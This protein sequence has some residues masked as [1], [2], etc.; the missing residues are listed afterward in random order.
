MPNRYPTLL[1]P[2]RLNDKVIL[3]NHITFP[4]ALQG[5]N[6]GPETFPSDAQFA[7]AN[8][9]A[10]SGASLFSYSH[11]GKFGGG[12]V[13]NR[14]AGGDKARIP[15]FDYDDPSMWNYMCQ[16]TTQAHMY[17]SRILI[18]FAAA[19][20]AG[21][22]YYGGNAR[23]LFPVPGSG[24][25]PGGPSGPGGGPGGPGG[26]PGG[27]KPCPKE[28]FPQVMDEMIDM[29][30]KYR[31]NGFDGM[32]FRLDRYID[33]ATNIR[34]DEYGGPIENRGRFLVELFTRVKDEVGRDFIIEGAL[35]YT[36]DHG[37]DGELPFGYSF[38]EVC[39]LARMLE[40]NMDIIQLREHTATGYHPTGYNVTR[41]EHPVLEYS[42]KLKDTGV[43]MTV[44]VN[45]G[46]IEPEEMEEALASGACDLISAGRALIAEPDFTRKIFSGVEV[47][48]PCIQ[49]N[50]CHGTMD[51]SPSYSFCSVN[52]RAGDQ[53]RLHYQIKPVLRAKKVAVIGGGPIGMRAACFA[54]QRGHQVTLFEKSGYLGGKLKYADVYDFKWPMK[55]Y[56]LWLIDELARRGVEVRLNCEPAPADI[57]AQ[58]FDAVIACTGSVARR[59]PVEGADSPAVYTSEDV[60][61]GRAQIGSRVIVVGGSSVP[62]ET[63]MH[64]AARGCQV[65]LISRQ[66]SLAMDMMNPHDGLHANFEKI[67][68]ELGYGQMLPM[69]E[70]YDNLT[71]ILDAVTTRVTPN[72]VTY[73][74]D[75]AETTLDCDT[76]I[77]NGGY[78]PCQD[79]ALQYCMSVPEFYMAGDCEDL[80]TNLQQG[81]VSAYGKANLL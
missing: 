19:W 20:P 76:V 60:Y 7:A 52:P 22:N 28:L 13:G 63:A 36:Q 24:G 69:W 32:S 35:P 42:R 1:S 15:I 64:L 10:V 34:T 61:E 67:Y 33:S 53:H 51:G 62:V 29:L 74:K 23:Q 54:A 21:T 37:A 25:G 40:G 11:Y 46:F 26:G 18:K 57:T 58:G 77:V 75:S 39:Q 43:K 30:K 55:R 2:Y 12:S 27:I 41:G 66:R 31:D 80:C 5:L 71:T 44:T 48:T 3:K 73:C 9:I 68:P 17:G 6:Q 47:P 4:S 50:K 81:N 56:R 16:L 59:P 8:D 72:S 78:A 38:E 49:C 14:K 70:K 79:A 65:T 45:A